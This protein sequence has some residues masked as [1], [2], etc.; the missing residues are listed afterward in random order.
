MEVAMKIIRFHKQFTT[1]GNLFFLICLLAAMLQPTETA[2]AQTVTNISFQADIYGSTSLER[3]EYPSTLA[4][5]YWGGFGTNA[6]MY[7]SLIAG[8]DQIAFAIDRNIPLAF[9]MD[10][11]TQ[12]GDQLTLSLASADYPNG[13]VES[14]SSSELHFAWDINQSGL[15]VR[16]HRYAKLVPNDLVTV[17]NI[18]QER[19]EIENLGPNIEL[20]GFSEYLHMD[21]VAE[22]RDYDNDGETE[23][24]LAINNFSTQRYPV[25]GKVYLPLTDFETRFEITGNHAVVTQ[26]LPDLRVN[27]DN[28]Q[29][30]TTAGFVSSIAKNAVDAGTEIAADAAVLLN[31][32]VDPLHNI[33]INGSFETPSVRSSTFDTYR[34]GQSFG[35]WTVESGSIDHISGNY[36]RASDGLQSVDL[37]GSPGN[38]TIY[39]DLATVPQHT[40]QLTFDLSGNPEGAPIV[41]QI[42]I[43]WGETLLDS[44]IYDTTGNSNENMNW[45]SRTYMVT[46]TAT[47]TRL[48]FKS[49]TSGS[50]GPVV[51]NVR[52]QDRVAD[53]PNDYSGQQ[54][55]LDKIGVRDAWRSPNYRGSSNIVV[56]ILDTGVDYTVADLEQNMWTNVDENPNDGIDN[57]NN[58]YIDD[59][60]GWDFTTSPGDN[61]P[62]PE[63]NTGFWT[64]GTAIAGIIGADHDDGGVDGINWYVKLMPIRVIK[65]DE[66]N[67]PSWGGCGAP[68]G[69]PGTQQRFANGIDYAIKNK[70]N[71]IVIAT[72]VPSQLLP[73]PTLPGLDCLDQAISRAQAA[74]VLIVASAGNEGESSVV[75]PA[76]SDYVMAVGATDRDD[77]RLNRV[78]D[79]I[80]YSS[81]YGNALDVVAPGWDFPILQ[82]GSNQYNPHAAGTSFS[83]PQV[84]GV[85]ALIMAANPAL[86]AQQV[87]TLV[88]GFA[89]EVGG[90]TYQNGFH[91]EMGWGRIN[92]YNALVA[93]APAA[94]PQSGG[95]ILYFNANYDCDERRANNGYV[96]RNS[97]GW[98]NI[99]DGMNENASSV[100][101]PSGWSVKLYADT[102]KRGASVCYNQSIDDFAQRGFFPGTSISIND[103]VSSIEVFNNSN[104]SPVNWY[105]STLGNLLYGESSDI[106]IPA[107][108]NGNGADDVAVYRPG[109]GMW[110][111]STLGDFR[112]G[113][114]GDLLVPADYNGDGRDDVAVYRPSN[115]MWY[116]STRG[117]F[118][119][120][121]DGDI[122]VPGDYNGDGWDDIAVYR[123]SNGTWY[124]STRGNFVYGQNGD[125]PVRADYNGDGRDDI[126]VFRPSNGTWYISTRG[127][128]VYGE[129]GDIPLP[130]DYNG[131]GWAD[132]A[133]FRPSIGMWYISTRGNFLFGEESDAPV[134]GDY[135]GDGFD[136]IAVYRP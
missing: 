94:C 1:L 79:G 52:V 90:Y 49:L 69:V 53:I 11:T 68:F 27:T 6:H 87:R 45:N 43:W 81:N 80:T 89:E 116:I 96:L 72:K 135:N 85:A 136:D 92:A 37:T 102:D 131:D 108:Y 16:L 54:W 74:N 18:I 93:A 55:Y 123:P 40:Y 32:Q 59:Y 56:A 97:E 39:Q 4:F 125:V 50:Y 22:T 112:F 95:V 122:P 61:D 46:A 128:F 58:G 64:H 110:Y 28:R 62:R 82:P 106:P 117:N 107:D 3:I 101:I 57:D 134:P 132:M 124:I 15:H 67:G 130:G 91:P 83:A 26:D 7:R 48:A 121:E 20:T 75:Y 38:A 76:S 77:N 127:N 19:Y 44:T 23:T 126:A 24:L 30:L 13:T 66:G 60:R 114:S 129:N 111:I 133:V 86:N 71:I 47:T 113:E 73:G 70:A 2:G 88:E 115:G 8:G 33:V 31:Q 118:H 21:D 100:K 12:A 99:T 120:G 5:T 41:K 78:I 29:S 104:C 109:S 36:W 98:Q 119:F 63:P 51:D 35:G 17:R 34:G 10:V 103:Q 9:S 25:F 105:I 42:E 84:A 14:I 65:G